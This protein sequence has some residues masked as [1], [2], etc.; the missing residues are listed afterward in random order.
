MSIRM[1]VEH[2]MAAWQQ[3]WTC[4]NCCTLVLTNSLPVQ[5]GVAPESGLNE[6]LSVAFNKEFRLQRSSVVCEV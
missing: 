5:P 2:S 1:D 3:A 4:K 6:Y